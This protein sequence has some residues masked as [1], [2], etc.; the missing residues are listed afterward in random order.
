MKVSVVIPAFNEEE[1]IGGVIR[2]VPRGLV[3]EVIVVDNGSTDSTA[4]K[5]REAG[6]VV[7]QERSR[8]YG[9][10]CHAGL[11]AT[12]SADTIVFL[13]G[14]RSDDP[15]DLPNLLTPIERGA[16]DFVLGARVS[17][18]LQPGAMAPH[19]RM[20]NWAV[21]RLMNLVYG[22]TIT[23]IASFRAIN[24]D[25]LMSLGMK[26]MTYGW[27]VEMLVKAAKKGARIEEVPINYRKRIGKSKVSGTLKG[28][29][30]AAYYMIWIP[31]RYMVKD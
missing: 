11:M 7:V 10:A 27:P 17:E 1:A 18:S 31:I 23:D 9:A 24:R 20:G 29:I 5:A 4:A 15:G 19:A 13:D 22:L 14:D 26:E 21:A 2:G 6:A 8:G 30:L 28:S 16:A 12:G 3:S 25:L